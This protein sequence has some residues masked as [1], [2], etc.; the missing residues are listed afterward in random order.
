MKYGARLRKS[1]VFLYRKHP[2]APRIA[3]SLLIAKT[4]SGYVRKSH[5]H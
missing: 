1:G 3:V 2:N 4:L 5:I